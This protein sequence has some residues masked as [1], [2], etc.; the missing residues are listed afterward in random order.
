MCFVLFFNFLLVDKNL[1]QLC[2]Q[3]SYPFYQNSL[4]FVFTN[5][6]NKPVFNI[7]TKNQAPYKQNKT[8]KTST[9]FSF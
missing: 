3:K 6:T 8:T 5:L 4:K 1:L 7:Q 2:K 9:D